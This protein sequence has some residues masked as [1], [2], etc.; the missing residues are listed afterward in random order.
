M[1]AKFN[2]IIASLKR[3]IKPT[4]VYGPLLLFCM[5]LVS[6][7]QAQETVTIDF[8]ESNNGQDERISQE[9]PYLEDGYSISP[10]SIH[11]DT[12]GN[13]VYLGYSENELNS[14]ITIRRTDGGGFRPI[15]FLLRGRFNTDNSV[16]EAFGILP[17]GDQV[18]LGRYQVQ[19]NQEIQESFL[20]ISGIALRITLAEV[21]TAFGSGLTID[22]IVLE[23]VITRPERVVFTQFFE[24]GARN[25]SSPITESQTE[26]EI[27][28]IPITGL[29]A[30][31]V[32]FHFEDELGNI[33]PRVRSRMC[34]VQPSGSTY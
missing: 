21:N 31:A 34:V 10:D 11:T 32:K 6:H 20:D 17:G 22:D 19:G 2:L 16:L 12:V 26:S 33:V 9:M 1:N 5:G 3:R 15:S 4:L 23:S 24:Y 13:G 8:N 30:V 25:T 28:I 14:Y 27:T 18:F 29:R 7:I